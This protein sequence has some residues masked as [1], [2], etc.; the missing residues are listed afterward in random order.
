MQRE[1][2]HAHRPV[3]VKAIEAVIGAD[4]DRVVRERISSVE[5]DGIGR[6]VVDRAPAIA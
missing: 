3:M 2:F 6:G 1:I 5:N 4:E